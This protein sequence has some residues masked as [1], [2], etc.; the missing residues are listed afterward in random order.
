MFSELSVSHS[1]R[2]LP[3]GYTVTTRPCYGAV[4]THPTGMLSCFKVF[5]DPGKKSKKMAEILEIQKR[6]KVRTLIKLEFNSKQ[7]S[8]V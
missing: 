2:N 4:S 8:S 1:D 7:I 6:K 3:H 5:M